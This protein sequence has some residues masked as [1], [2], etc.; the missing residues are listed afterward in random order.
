MKQYRL[1]ITDKALLDMEEIYNYIAEQLHAPEAAMGQ[2]NSKGCIENHAKIA[3]PF[4][5]QR[6]A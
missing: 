5:L 6:R 1:Q 4:Y 3:L 2:Y